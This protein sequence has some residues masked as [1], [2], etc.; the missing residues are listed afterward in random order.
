MLLG[1]IPMF[2]FET[3]RFFGEKSQKSKNWKSRHFGLLLRSVGNPRHGVDLHQGV[4]CLAVAMLRCQNG[5]PRVRRGVATVHRG[6][7]FGFLFRKSSI[8]TPIV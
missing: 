7:I 5:T 8:C 3:L 6:K 1:V 4:G 2:C